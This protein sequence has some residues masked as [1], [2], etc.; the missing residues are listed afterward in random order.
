M[1]TPTPEI[2]WLTASPRSAAMPQAVR[3][4]SWGTA[5]GIPELNNLIKR[6]TAMK[7]L[8]W[9]LFVLFTLVSVPALTPM[10][11]FAQS[12]ALEVKCADANGNAVSGVKVTIDP[13][14][15]HKVK[16]KKSDG[17]GISEF[18][19]LD[20][21][22]YRVF[23]RKEGMAPA[24]YE[25][26]VLKG[27][28]RQSITLSFQAGDMTKKL[29][30]ED[31][32]QIQQSYAN[33]EQANN[34]L[35]GGKLA[36]AEKAYLV[37]I[38]TNPAN[39][40]PHLNVG[41]CYLQEGK[42][43]PAEKSLKRAVELAGALK[44][45]PG[46][47]QAVY[48]M[49]ADRAQDLISKLPM[50]RLRNEADKALSARNYDEAASKYREA[51]KY[52][53]NEPDLHYNLSLALANG[54]KFEEANKEADAAIQIVQKNI[55]ATQEGLK[56]LPDGSPQKAQETARLTELNK[57]LA[58][59]NDLKKR[60]EEFRENEIL[61]Q[62][63][64][65][66]QDGDKLYSSED[67]ANALK[68]YQEALPMIQGPKQSIVYAQ[69]GRTY[70]KLKQGDQAVASFRKAM[71]LSP[72]NDEYRKALAQ[73]YLNEKKYEEA[74]NLYAEG[75]GGEKDLFSLGQKLSS[76]G[77]SEVAALAFERVI[78][79]NP[80]NAEACYELG[81]ILYQEKINDARAKELLD[82]YSQIGHDAAHLDNIKGVL[83][84][85]KRRMSK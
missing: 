38:E 22:V 29:P 50:I 46:Q 23:G 51:L 68:K 41:L 5:D 63:Q 8:R 6:I 18:T 83:A 44:Q 60:A 45:L 66:L 59:Y 40:E 16:D 71:E 2:G 48:G 7:N 39:P 47:Q 12:N 11:A 24:S 82:K 85:L 74:L 62:A 52:D 78:K 42:W 72:G 17:K 13:M 30:F 36:D 15:T 54:K 65:M 76:Q 19:K 35:R 34:L 84:V 9:G 73:Y 28:A 1:R 26:V 57:S 55:Q 37:A 49:I 56:T 58:A 21:G 25:F 64:V 80:Q 69:I 53:Q 70:G 32:A 61:K 77:N 31:Q 10:Q 20:D 79:L 3:A 67:Y 14:D 75:G 4:V 27:G 43:E 33:V 81:M